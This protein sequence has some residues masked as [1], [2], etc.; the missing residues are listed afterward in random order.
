MSEQESIFKLGT[1]Q[2]AEAFAQQIKGA[3]TDK[4]LREKMTDQIEKCII[5]HRKYIKDTVLPNDSLQDDLEGELYLAITEEVKKYDPQ[6]EKG[7]EFSTYTY[8]N[9]RARLNK[10]LD[11]EIHSTSVTGD[12][13]KK[14]IN[15]LRKYL[16]RESELSGETWDHLAGQL[17]E[18]IKMTEEEGEEEGDFLKKAKEELKYKKNSTLRKHLQHLIERDAGS[19]S[20]DMP[21]GDNDEDGILSDVIEDKNADIPGEEYEK[22]INEIL[23]DMKEKTYEEK[24]RILEESIGR[25]EKLGIAISMLRPEQEDMLEWLMDCSGGDADFLVRIWEK[26]SIP[27]KFLAELA[28]EYRVSE[29]TVSSRWRLARREIEHILNN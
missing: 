7:A 11:K 20:L 2:V 3:D 9:I 28:K 5:I 8:N 21:I 1:R 16:K 22:I 10:M 14:E 23:F 17:L 4:A 15:K 6:N 29:C 26:K 12:A 25:K 27:P 13:E 24:E 18:Q 19:L